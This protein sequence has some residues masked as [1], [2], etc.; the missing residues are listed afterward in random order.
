MKVQVYYHKSQGI[1]EVC[2]SVLGRVID[3]DRIEVADVIPV[4]V[5]RTRYIDPTD[6]IDVPFSELSADEQDEV[7]EEA[8]AEYC[9][10]A[11]NEVTEFHTHN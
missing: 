3:I 2:V 11:G 9:N 7:I 5:E 1:A 10:G 6:T 8:I 4:K